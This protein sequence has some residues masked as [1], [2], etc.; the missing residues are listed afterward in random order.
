MGVRFAKIASDV[1][2]DPRL[3]EMVALAHSG[4]CPFCKRDMGKMPD[5]HF[6]DE[7]SVSEFKISGLCQDCQDREYGR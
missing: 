4:R 6:R 5:T 7:L 2:G 1:I 3:K